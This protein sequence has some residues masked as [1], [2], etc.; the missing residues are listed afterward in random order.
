[1]LLHRHLCIYFLIGVFAL[2]P[3]VASSQRLALQNAFLASLDS[4][5]LSSSPAKD[6]AI[7]YLKTTIGAQKYFEKDSDSIQV[8]MNRFENRFFDYFLKAAI[9]Y[10]DSSDIPVPWKEYYAK[11]N[12]STIRQMLHG[13]NAH[14]NNDLWQALTHE[15]T[16]EEIKILKKSYYSFHSYLQQDYNDIYDYAIA[17]NRRMKRLHSLSLGIDKWYGAWLLKKWRKRQYTIAE[18][19][20]TN[21]DKFYKKKKKVE[22]KLVAVNRLIAFYF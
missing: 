1:M 11:P 19:F 4:I 7:V 18:L 16:L 8:L 9:A 17:S 15:F 6:F 10:R 2:F 5:S 3:S 21:S 20:Y 12:S 22:R 13:I 14:M